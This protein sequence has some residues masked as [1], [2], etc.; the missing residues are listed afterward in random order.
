MSSVRFEKIIQYI[1]PMGSYLN[2]VI[3]RNDDDDIVDVARFF[4]MAASA[5]ERL[6]FSSFFF[7]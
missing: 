6:S 4:A 7:Y 2:A 1:F 5:D 3:N